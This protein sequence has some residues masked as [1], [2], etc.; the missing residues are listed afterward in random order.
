MK[1]FQLILKNCQYDDLRYAQE[2]YNGIVNYAEDYDIYQYTLNTDEL[3]QKEIDLI[4]IY[5]YVFIHGLD[6]NKDNYISLYK[7]VST[8]KILFIAEQ[9]YKK[10]L[11]YINIEYI[12]LL[13]KNCYK[14]VFNTCIDNMHKLLYT[15]NDN[16]ASNFLHLDFIYNVDPTCISKPH[17]KEIIQIS[18]NGLNSRYDIFINL[19]IYKKNLFSDFIWKLYNVTKNIQTLSIDKLFIDKQTG[20]TS[21]ITNFDTSNIINNRI[22]VYNDL[23]NNDKFNLLSSAY[24]ACVFDKYTYIN[25]TIL[26][27]IC[28]GTIPIFYTKYASKIMIN[29]KQSIY[30]IIKG[31]YIDDSTKFNDELYTSVHKY[32][33]SENTYKSIALKNI[34]IC[35]NVF[36]PQKIVK[37]LLININ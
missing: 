25:Y 23:S 15:F 37:E 36:N 24:F 11:T 18:N 21:Q 8:K 14:V 31:I 9:N 20:N 34:N 4:N 19:F 3:L 29:D 6:S 13:I 1:I 7:N 32:I 2:L 17:N 16:S 33:I 28:N 12:H 26:D 35:N 27:I 30:N 10:F 22:N 5:D